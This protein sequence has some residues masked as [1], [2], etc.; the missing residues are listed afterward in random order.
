MYV[1]SGTCQFVVSTIIK[2]VIFILG[3]VCSFI[4]YNDPQNNR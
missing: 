3:I 1:E 2:S 4:L